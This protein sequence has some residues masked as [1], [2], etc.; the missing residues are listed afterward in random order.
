MVPPE[1]RLNIIL[2]ITVKIQVKIKINSRHRAHRVHLGT[3][4]LL[5]NIFMWNLDSLNNPEKKKMLKI[6]LNREK[7]RKL[8]RIKRGK[9]KI[10]KMEVQDP[11]ILI[12][13]RSI[14]VEVKKIQMGKVK[15][16]NNLVKVLVDRS[17]MTRLLKNIFTWEVPLKGKEMKKVG[18]KGIRRYKVQ[19]RNPQPKSQLPRG[20]KLRSP[21]PK[22][23]KLRSPLPRSLKLRSPLLKV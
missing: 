12:N 21:L 14:K 17:D 20:L 1:V 16:L 18:P 11:N 3:M 10:L 8:M 13:I 4:R 7:L 9:R 15:S 19:P 6:T 5:K 2:E 22:S 23:L